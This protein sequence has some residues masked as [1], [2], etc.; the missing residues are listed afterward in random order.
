MVKNEPN[1]SHV[2]HKTLTEIVGLLFTV[3]ILFSLCYK[4]WPSGKWIETGKIQGTI[5]NFHVK[6]KN[7]KRLFYNV[8]LSDGKIITVE[9]YPKRTYNSGDKIE[10]YVFEHEKNKSRKKYN[11][12]ILE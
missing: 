5:Q 1:K 2:T 9:S 12:V 8:V 10:L 6:G 11:F 7:S 3:I 4:F